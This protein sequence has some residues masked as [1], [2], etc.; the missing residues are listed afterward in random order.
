MSG[1]LPP[2]PIIMNR[3]RQHRVHCFVMAGLRGRG[4]QSWRCRPLAGGGCPGVFGAS[5][6]PS[7]ALRVLP[8][9]AARA[10]NGLADREGSGE[11]RA[12]YAES[13]DSGSATRSGVGLLGCRSRVSERRSRVRV[14]RTDRAGGSHAV[15]RCEFVLLP[16]EV[17]AQLGGVAAPGE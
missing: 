10:G 8:P 15:L 6:T 17:L 3:E 13:G 2:Q 4:C 7:A 11:D 14:R 9:L 5:R 16:V 12:T 1:A